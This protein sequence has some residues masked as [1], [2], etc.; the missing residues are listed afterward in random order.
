MS[1][2]MASA[3]GSPLSL[4]GRVETPPSVAVRTGVDIQSIESF[5]TMETAVFESITTRSFTE[6]ERRYCERTGDPPQHYAARWAA[7][8]A[9]RKCIDEPIP[10]RAIGVTRSNGRPE[11][12]LKWRGRRSLTDTL[13]TEQWRT[14]LSLSHDTTADTAVAQVVVTAE[15][16][17]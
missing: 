7:K 8:E 17:G 12:Q 6:A 16:D 13:G 9:V 11:L 4:S 14:D 3:S 10:F 5:R 2:E 1:G 15:Y